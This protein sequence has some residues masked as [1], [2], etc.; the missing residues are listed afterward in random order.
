M[1]CWHFMQYSP[2]NGRTNCM[3]PRLDLP[4]VMTDEEEVA[5]EKWR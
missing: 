1:S 4:S 5:L 3:A 2:H